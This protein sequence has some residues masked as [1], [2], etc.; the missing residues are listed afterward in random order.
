MSW[1]QITGYQSS[2]K[3]QK[4]RKLTPDEIEKILSHIPESLA[5][6][7]RSRKVIR[8]GI[9]SFLRRALMNEEID[10]RGINMLI[11]TIINQHAKSRV[12]PGTPVGITAA[13]SHGASASQGALNSFHSSGASKSVTNAIDAIRDIIYA[14]ESPKNPKMDIFY[15]KRD[16]SLGEVIDLKGIIVGSTVKDYIKDYQLIQTAKFK[17]PFWY[18]AFSLIEPDFVI[19][20]DNVS[21]IRLIINHNS[22]YLQRATIKDIV[23]QLK[24]NSIECCDYV[25]SPT[26]IGI[27]DVY[28]RKDVLN[29]YKKIPDNEGKLQNVLEVEF[30]SNVLM[31][32]LSNIIVKGVEGIEKL[33]PIKH[34]KTIALS[35][36]QAITDPVLIKEYSL[37]NGYWVYYIPTRMFRYGITPTELGKIMEDAGLEVLF[38]E[39]DNYRIMINSDIPIKNI[40]V[41]IESKIEE[42]TEEYEKDVAKAIKSRNDKYK[43]WPKEA[44][45]RAVSDLPD[46]PRPQILLDAFLIY[47]ES[48]GCTLDKMLEIPEV[49]QH[50]VTCNN[51]HIIAKKFGIEAA[52]ATIIRLMADMAESNY[53]H[54]EHINIIAEF[55]TSKGRPY[56]ATYTGISRQATGHLSLATLV[57]ALEVFSRN[58]MIGKSEDMRNVSAAIASGQR[59]SV[60]SGYNEIGCDV[61]VEGEVKTFTGEEVYTA[62]NFDDKAKKIIDESLQ[63]ATDEEDLLGDLE[64]SGLEYGSKIDANQFFGKSGTDKKISVG[65]TTVPKIRQGLLN[66]INYTRSGVPV[67]ADY[68][69]IPSVRKVISEGMLTFLEKKVH[70]IGGGIP[71]GIKNYYD[72]YKKNREEESR[73]IEEKQESAFRESSRISDFLPELDFEEILS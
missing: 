19:P 30:Y 52:R 28:V 26:S 4:P 43:N 31:T 59:I 16:I 29:K 47:S 11:N 55:I 12:V 37:Q 22:L 62:Y 15:K 57:R 14:R 44:F 21:F 8:D 73:I 7:K 66:V 38:V 35:T 33:Y 60:G 41:H 69:S 51:V 34:D 54:P 17:A 10:V 20:T 67:R 6:D 70:I 32:S 23:E 46:V 39:R 24:Q 53:I 48:S 1:T 5:A 40:K 13:E 71:E 64:N 27:I 25:Y 58:A 45:A 63:I 49:D 56:G 3:V 72:K 65:R 42:A 2:E 36:S 18:E 9:V 50:L 61:V 68:T